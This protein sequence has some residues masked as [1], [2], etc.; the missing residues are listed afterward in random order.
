[1]AGS[2]AQFPKQLPADR[3]LPGQSPIDPFE[4]FLNPI[5]W[6]SD[7][8][9]FFQKHCQKGTGTRFYQSDIET[10]RPF[11]DPSDRTEQWGSGHFTTDLNFMVLFISW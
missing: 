10:G 3:Q 9:E 7:R 6:F 2:R 1:M 11:A 5:F 4:D 8:S